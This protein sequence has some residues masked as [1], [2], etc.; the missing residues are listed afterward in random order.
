MATCSEPTAASFN[1]K[2]RASGLPF[3]LR[4]FSGPSGNSHA[5]I[6][7]YIG[8]TT[9]HVVRRYQ[10][11]VEHRFVV[12]GSMTFVWKTKS[13]QILLSAPDHPPGEESALTQP[14]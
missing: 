6:I 8:A 7:S 3:V 12:N 4:D 2:Q 11:R 10:K 14:W 13:H 1:R 5:H 9:A